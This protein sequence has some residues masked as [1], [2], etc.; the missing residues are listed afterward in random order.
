MGSI[1]SQKNI[2]EMVRGKGYEL[3][4]GD[5]LMG[6][7]RQIAYELQVPCIGIQLEIF[8]VLHYCDHIRMCERFYDTEPGL[9]ENLS[10]MFAKSY[11][12]TFHNYSMVESNNDKNYY[13]YRV[14]LSSKAI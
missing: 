11:Y 8:R 6:Y 14:T 12:K 5:F 7:G 13:D 2:V 1:F 4:L 10:P 3:V 9:I